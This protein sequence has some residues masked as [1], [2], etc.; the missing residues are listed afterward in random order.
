[1][2]VSLMAYPVKVS[3][4]EF[5]EYTLPRGRVVSMSTQAI[6]GGVAA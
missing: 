2:A 6:I 3:S 4:H 1:M 5:D